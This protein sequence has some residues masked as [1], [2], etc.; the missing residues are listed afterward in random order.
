[1]RVMQEISDFTLIV[2][3]YVIQETATV[4]AYRC[5]LKIAKAHRKQLRN[6]HPHMR[7]CVRVSP[8]GC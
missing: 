5:S 1:M 6:L 4:L 3:P 2:H 8:R 7:K